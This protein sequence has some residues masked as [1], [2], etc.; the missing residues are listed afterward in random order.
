MHLHVDSLPPVGPNADAPGAELVLLHGWGMNNGVWAPVLDRLRRTH[1]LSLI[2]LPGH[3]ASEYRQSQASLD[4]WARAALE[5]APARAIW[6]GWSLGGQLA[7]QAALR[8]PER[9]QSL[10]LVAA[11]PRFVTAGDWP[12][13]MPIATFR[14]FAANL[15]RDH[16]ATLERFLALQ[17]RGAV[18]ARDTLRR[19]KAALRERPAPC[20]RALDNGLDLLLRTD[21]RGK[22]RQLACPSLWLLGERDTLVPADVAEDLHRLLPRAEVFL[23]PGA[24]HAP[25]LSNPEACLRLMAG[26]LGDAERG[27]P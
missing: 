8:A 16:A 2:E 25:F 10:V 14:E 6:L 12:H 21:F 13:A 20:D 18:E 3:G 15:A 26:F 27:E 1:R 17:V 22:L 7:L 11:S 19:L 24:A 4:D 5:A 9:V 23:L